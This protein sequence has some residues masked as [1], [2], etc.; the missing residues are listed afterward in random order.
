MM[1][2]L[3]KKNKKKTTS[4]GLLC[5]ENRSKYLGQMSRENKRKNL[6]RKLL[7]LVWA[8]TVALYN[9]AWANLNRT[10]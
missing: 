7:N 1:P 4:Q 10:K 2:A 6:S 9:R 5:D 8:Y 3:H